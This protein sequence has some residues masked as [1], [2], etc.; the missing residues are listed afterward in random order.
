MEKQG[1]TLKLVPLKLNEGLSIGRENIRGNTVNNRN[2]G[3]ELKS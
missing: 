1:L 3:S 2:L